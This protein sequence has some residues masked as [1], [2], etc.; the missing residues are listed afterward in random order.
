MC[1]HIVSLL[2]FLNLY[3]CSTFI[4]GVWVIYL[5]GFCVDSGMENVSVEK[6]NEWQ[7]EEMI[8]WSCLKFLLLLKQ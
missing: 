8:P 7:L 3:N 1:T 2:E 4:C 6:E 5:Q